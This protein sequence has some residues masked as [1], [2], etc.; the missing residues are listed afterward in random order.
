M[1]AIG[2]GATVGDWFRREPPFV[3][4]GTTAFAVEHIAFAICSWSKVGS[5]AR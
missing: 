5:V 3:H 1:S 4:T 2:S